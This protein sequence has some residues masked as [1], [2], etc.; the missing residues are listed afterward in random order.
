MQQNTTELLARLGKEE[1]D[2][3]TFDLMNHLEMSV[4]RGSKLARVQRDSVNEFSHSSA[5]LFDSQVRETFQFWERQFKDLFSELGLDL[6]DFVISGNF[7]E[8]VE[9]L[10][11][12]WAEFFVLETGVSIY[13]ETI[14]YI[15]ES[16]LKSTDEI[17]P[18]GAQGEYGDNYR[19]THYVEN[20]T[21]S[22]MIP[23][24]LL[25]D[26]SVEDF[27]NY[28]SYFSGDGFHLDTLP[29]YL[30]GVCASPTASVNLLK[31]INEI[32]PDFSQ[33]SGFCFYIKKWVQFP[34]LINPV[35]DIWLLATLEPANIA[36]SFF[37]S[38][39]D[40][41]DMSVDKDSLEGGVL[42]EYNWDFVS[43]GIREIFELSQGLSF[44]EDLFAS[45]LLG[46]RIIEEF[47]CERAR[48]EDH[49]NSEFGIVRAVVFCSPKL[50]PSE[51]QRVDQRDPFFKNQD[52]MDLITLFWARND[53][54]VVI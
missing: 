52:F 9:E 41:Q 12:Y 33:V 36:N 17:G 7:E 42:L 6:E 11:D 53:L 48:I 46:Q 2:G 54:S 44:N 43:D 50:E 47:R 35:T 8:L 19:I 20:L 18:F 30:V 37:E 10:A 1:R 21:L 51:K 40:T 29:A 39:S 4:Q 3:A 28:L 49:I 38:K 27:A 31:A 24:S 16:L 14:T 22:P 26:I 32:E 23:R 5:Q 25:W 15:F 45:A 13:P 34:L